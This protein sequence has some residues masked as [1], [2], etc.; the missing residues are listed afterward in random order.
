MSPVL[1][2]APQHNAPQIDPDTWEGPPISSLSEVL[3]I[4]LDS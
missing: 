2:K 4:A 3:P 1:I